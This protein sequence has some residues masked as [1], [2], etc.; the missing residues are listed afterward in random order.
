MGLIYKHPIFQEPMTILFFNMIGKN[1]KYY[2]N[3]K[4][5]LKPDDVY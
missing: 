2:K 4:F 1:Q 3:E 5:S